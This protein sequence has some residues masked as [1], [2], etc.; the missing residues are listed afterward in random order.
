VGMEQTAQGSGHDPKLLKFRTCL[1]N[2]LRH[3][4]PILA[5]TRSW[6]YDPYE[7]LPD[8]VVL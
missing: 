5:G 8:W 3:M 2:A 1:G 4:I 6:T 7:L